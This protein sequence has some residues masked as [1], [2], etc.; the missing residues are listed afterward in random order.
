MSLARGAARGAAWNFATVLA[1]RGFGFVILGLLLRTI[2]ASV[3]TLIP[4]EL[5][6][7]SQNSAS[8]TARVICASV[9]IVLLSLG[10]RAG[11]CCDTALG[12]VKA[13]YETRPFNPRHD[14]GMRQLNRWGRVQSLEFYA[15]HA[16][17]LIC[18]LVV[19]FARSSGGPRCR[20]PQRFVKHSESQ[21]PGQRVRSRPGAVEPL[22]IGKES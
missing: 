3:V 19:Q 11:R 13:P 1:E 14:G 22:S 20:H 8:T 21:S 4:S 2:P 17:G 9:F 5:T 7:G 12:F 15:A 10:G 6:E 16:I 18:A